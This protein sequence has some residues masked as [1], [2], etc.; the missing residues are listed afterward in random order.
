[1]EKNRVI[2][3]KGHTIGGNEKV[4]I[5]GP[6]AVESKEQIMQS[7]EQLSRLG[8][9]FL[10]GGVFK[11]RTSPHSF[12]GLGEEGLNYIRQAADAFDMLVVSEIMSIDQLNRFADKIDIIQIGARNMYNYSLLKELGKLAKPV[13]LK[14]AFSATY[15]EWALATEYITHGGNQDVILVERGIRTFERSLRFT[16]DVS[17]FPYMKKL[18]K[19]PIIADPSHA[20][21]ER[22]FV[23]PLA[24]AGL[25]A[26]ADGVIVEVHPEPEQALSDGDQSIVLAEFGEFLAGIRPLM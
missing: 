4:I 15:E 19:L 17:A 5:A 21:G 22:D 25:A 14:R 12:Q 24:K 18:T 20:A 9:N 1:M 13:I 6:C 2:E 3:I 16:F 10:R 23:L 7:A 8:V 11:P 26:G